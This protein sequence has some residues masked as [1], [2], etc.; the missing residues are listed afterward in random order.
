MRE[1]AFGAGAAIL[2]RA[3]VAG[4]VAVVGLAV[5]LSQGGA[6]ASPPGKLGCRAWSASTLCTLSPI[7]DRDGRSWFASLDY[8]HGRNLARI[9]ERVGRRSILAGLF[10]FGQEPTCCLSWAALSGLAEPAFAFTVGGGADWNPSIVVSRVGGRWRELRF[11]APGY[12]DA[13][14]RVVVDFNHMQGGLVELEANSTGAAAGPET[15]QWYR[16]DEH[17]FVPTAPPGRSASCAAKALAG[18]PRIYTDKASP[19]MISS[20]ACLD[21]WALARG[22]LHRQVVYGLYEQRGTAWLRVGVG[23]T[24]SRGYVRVRGLGSIGFAVPQSVLRRLVALV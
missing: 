6:P 15:Y 2:R 18:A 21:G 5:G 8:V 4:A 1:G 13:K 24:I 23:A 19:Y 16:F 14:P 11:E 3:A 9:Y 20:V 22:T 10:K 12:R 7:I 17:I